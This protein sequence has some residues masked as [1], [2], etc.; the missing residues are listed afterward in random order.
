MTTKDVWHTLS[1]AEKKSEVVK[2]LTQLYTIEQG[3]HTL[4]GK[5]QQGRLANVKKDLEAFLI[6]TA[7]WESSR[8]QQ[9]RIL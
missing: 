1:E 7:E 3:K 6:N 2:T 5:R 8:Q 9:K 4:S